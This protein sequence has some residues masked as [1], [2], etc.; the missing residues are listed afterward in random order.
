LNPLFLWDAILERAWLTW[1]DASVQLWLFQPIKP[2]DIN[3][4]GQLV[5]SCEPTQLTWIAKRYGRWLGDVVRELGGE[6]LILRPR[7][8]EPV[9]L[10]ALAA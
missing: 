3:A 9:E 5:C 2:I 7:E 1:P 6:G 4:E 8:E 10:E